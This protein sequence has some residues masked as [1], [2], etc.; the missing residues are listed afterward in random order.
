MSALLSSM[1]KSITGAIKANIPPF[2]AIPG[3]LLL[4]EIKQRPG[5]SA[6]D[7]STAIISRLGAA[8]IPIGVNADGSENLI[9]KYTVIVAEEIINQIKTNGLVEAVI[10]PGSLVLVGTG[11][12]AAGPVEVTVTNTKPTV[13]K[14]VMV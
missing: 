9:N 3:L 1:L 4:C 10:E 5:L 13:A 6:V 2:P 12:S 7:L 11:V 14:G 8:G